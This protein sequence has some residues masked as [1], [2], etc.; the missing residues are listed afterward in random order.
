MLLVCF[1]LAIKAIFS[2]YILFA[3]ID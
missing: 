3:R 1:G 2:Y